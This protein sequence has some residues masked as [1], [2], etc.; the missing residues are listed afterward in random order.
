MFAVG[1]S[2][3]A[4]IQMQIVVDTDIHG[5]D[6][7]PTEHLVDSVNDF[8]DAV[9]LRKTFRFGPSTIVYLQLDAF[10]TVVA[11]SMH[12]CDAAGADEPY[13]HVLVYHSVSCN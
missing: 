2:S 13:S 9:F 1:K 8:A 4:E 6:V 5:V 10:T 3:Q 12:A 7:R 11:R